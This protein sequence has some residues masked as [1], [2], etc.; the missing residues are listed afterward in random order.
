MIFIKYFYRLD[1]IENYCITFVVL[2][3]TGG[4]KSKTPLMLTINSHPATG[5]YFSRIKKTFAVTKC[6]AWVCL[7]IVLV[8]NSCRVSLIADRDEVFIEH[9]LETALVVDAFYLQLM[10]ADTSQIQYSTFSDNWNNAELEIRQLRLMAEAHPLNRESS[11]ICSLLL[12]TFI[13]YKQ[14]HQK[15]NFYPPALLPLHRDRL[16]E[17]FIALLSVEKSKEL[18]N[19]KP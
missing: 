12:E 17:Y 9:V 3:T 15:N 2:L 8:F 5:H 4:F 11:E 6:G 19:Q 10:S 14:Q 7:S 18:K 13:K 16:A 1:E